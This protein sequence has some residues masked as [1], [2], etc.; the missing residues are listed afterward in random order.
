MFIFIEFYMN[1]KVFLNTQEFLCT[2]FLCTQHSVGP[3]T[4]ILKTAVYM[5]CI[6]YTLYTVAHIEFVNG[7]THHLNEFGKPERI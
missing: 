3:R 2:Q 6:G 5:N 1:A 7:Q 4:L